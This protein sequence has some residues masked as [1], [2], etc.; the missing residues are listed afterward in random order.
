MDPKAEMILE[1][2]RKYGLDSPRVFSAMLQVPREE[3]VGHKD[4]DIAYSDSAISIGFGQTISQPYTVAFMTHLLNLMGNEMVLE[5]GTGSGYQAAVLSILADRVFSVEIIPQLAQIAKKRL[6][7]LGFKNIEVKAGQGEVAWKDKAPYDAIIVTAG[8][9]NGITD[10]L[11]KQLKKDGIMVAPV[12]KGPDKIMTKFVKKKGKVEKK[13][14]GVFH[15]VPF[16][17]SN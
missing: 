5:I 12:G 17:E 10:V 7:K 9:E 16:V 1:I 4:K 14:F 8:V 3:F 6:K 11:L 15:F 13:E 2:K